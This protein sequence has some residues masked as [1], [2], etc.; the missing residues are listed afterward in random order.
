MELYLVYGLFIEIYLFPLPCRY[1]SG[2]KNRFQ[3]FI[4]YLREMGDEVQFLYSSVDK[5][6][7]FNFDI[8]NSAF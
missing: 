3:N 2:Y 6:Y 5:C 1:V 4:R 7:F 8:Y